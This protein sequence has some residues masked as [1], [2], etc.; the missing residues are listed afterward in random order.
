MLLFDLQADPEEFHNL[1]DDPAYHGKVL[2]YA[3]K[4][5][6]WHMNHDD[7]TLTNSLLTSGGVIERNGART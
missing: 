4:M 1:A 5:L 2:D 7:R 6:S 3:Q